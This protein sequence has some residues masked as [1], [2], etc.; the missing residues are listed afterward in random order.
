MTV[1]DLQEFYKTMLSAD[2]QAWASG[3]WLNTYNQ[4]EHGDGEERRLPA[5]IF[6]LDN[7]LQH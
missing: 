2:M 1:E 3:D 6:E 4:S 5:N 7:E